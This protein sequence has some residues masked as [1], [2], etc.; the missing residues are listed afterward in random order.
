[1]YDLNKSGQVGVFGVQPHAKNSLA[2]II[3]RIQQ[4]DV[5]KLNCFVFSES[6]LY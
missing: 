1:M 4:D 5:E 6:S 2:T 3:E